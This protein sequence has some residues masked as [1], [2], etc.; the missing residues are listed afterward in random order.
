MDSLFWGVLSIA[1]VLV[2]QS[3]MSL[4]FWTLWRRTG[5]GDDGF[6]RV[7]AVDRNGHPVTRDIRRTKWRERCLAGYCGS[8]VAGVEDV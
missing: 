4:F 3:P 1:G 2:V 7:M 8:D 6:R 5:T